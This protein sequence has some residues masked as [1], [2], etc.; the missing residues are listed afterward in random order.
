MGLSKNLV[1]DVAD[2]EPQTDCRKRRSYQLTKRVFDF[3]F[4]LLLIPFLIPCMTIIALLIKLNSRGPVFFSHKRVGK[5]GKLF[6]CYKFRTMVENAPELKAGLQHL[7]EMEG[8]AFKIKADPRITKLGRFLRRYSLDELPQ[9]FN[10]LKS[11]MSFVGPRPPLPEEVAKYKPWHRKRIS[12][13]PGLTCL[14]QI[15]GRNNIQSFDD[16]VKM[17]VEYI[18]KQSFVT[19]F[20][21]I[22]K[23][24]P[25]VVLKRGAY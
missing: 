9:V 10:I 6:N 15:S 4:A 14:W 23:T 24:M 17:D 1:L 21:I 19:D 2:L 7:N 16:W 12:V 3:F 8:P 22:L 18:E 25:V 13:T 5:G 11:E 20:K